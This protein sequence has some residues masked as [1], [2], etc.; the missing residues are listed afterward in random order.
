[1]SEKLPPLRIGRL[2][3]ETN[4]L[5]G[6]MS[7]ALTTAE[8]AGAVANNGGLGTIGGVGLG[9][10]EGTRNRNE[11]FKACQTRL[12]QEIENARE[13]SH[14]G[15]VGVNL[16]VATTDY[17]ELV[18][19]SVENGVKYIASGA[20][21]PLSLPEY[22]KK[23]K[24]SGQPTP[25]L[26][27]I[28][29]T[30]RAAELVLKRWGKDNVIPSAFIVE[31]PNAAG[32]HL[33]V[34]KANDIGKNEFSL[35]SVIPQLVQA[36]EKSGYDIPII[37]AGGIWDRDD[38]DR[39]IRLGASGVQMAT[40]FLTTDECNASQAFK[41]R[42]V[43]NT[44]PIVVIKSP[45]GLP[46]RAIENEFIQRVNDKNNDEEIDLGPCVHC[47]R[48]CE[49]AKNPLASYCI[50][51][52]L[53]NV[54]I[55]NVENGVLFTGINSDQLKTDRENGIFTANQVMQELTNPEN[56][57]H[58]M[59]E[60]LP[61]DDSFEKSELGSLQDLIKD[62]YEIRNIIEK[63]L[64]EKRSENPSSWMKNRNRLNVLLIKH[65]LSPEDPKCY[66]ILQ[67]RVKNALKELKKL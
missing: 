61:S 34:T 37:A 6:G 14:D 24:V 25:E 16:M 44:D 53:Y 42:H 15:N 59:P 49:H 19:I 54:R 65:D 41:D 17:Q 45:V 13:I 28:I 43:E 39:M 60:Q 31:T 32:G 27:P 26:I 63:M 11:Y 58:C 20:G 5:L 23:Y 38:I 35:E 51:R 67:A 64:Q 12:K 9:L 30:V 8:L 50:I 55:G 46:G 4:I 1:M 47:L 22:V 7:T 10:N 36:L 18:K 52:A 56:T 29:S 48:I 40:R 62:Y 33:G 21:L 3:A 2:E 66:T 57:D